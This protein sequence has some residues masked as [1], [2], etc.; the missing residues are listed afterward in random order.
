MVQNLD[1]RH[2]ESN[3]NIASLQISSNRKYPEFNYRS[4]F[5]Y[6]TKVLVKSDGQFLQARTSVV[7]QLHCYQS[8][9]APIQS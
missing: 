8:L 3:R 7:R 5:R 2:S 1:H 6:D 4:V 9:T